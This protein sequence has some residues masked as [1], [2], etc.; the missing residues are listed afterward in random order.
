MYSPSLHTQVLKSTLSASSEKLL[1][2]GRPLGMLLL[3]VVSNS[4]YCPEQLVQFM[5]AF[6]RS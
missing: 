2:I 3:A 6:P 4:S 1:C 5:L